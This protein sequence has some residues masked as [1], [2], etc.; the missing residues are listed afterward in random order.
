M[1]TVDVPP[2]ALLCFYTDGLVERSDTS[3]DESLKRLCE[4]I[5]AGPVESVCMTVMGQLIGDDLPGDDVAVLVLRREDSGEMGPLD[6][7]VPAQPQSL[8]RIRFE[9][10][11]WLLVVGAPPRVIANLLVAVGEA[12]TN[13]IEHAHQQHTVGLVA[14]DL[15]G[16]VRVGDGGL[17][18]GIG[19]GTQPRGVLSAVPAPVGSQVGARDHWPA[20]AR[21]A[22]RGTAQLPPPHRHRGAAHPSHV[23]STSNN[24]LAASL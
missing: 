19:E 3:L 21:G 1:T 22:D 13:A 4:A 17:A 6:L 5:L 23:S 7:A 8:Q 15:V 16:L 24:A 18:P 10:R 2:G 11:R 14:P 20:P 9:M 12:C